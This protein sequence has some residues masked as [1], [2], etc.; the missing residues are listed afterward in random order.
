MILLQSTYGGTV[1]Y[2]GTYLTALTMLDT[3]LPDIVEVN[4]K[5]CVFRNDERYTKNTR[6][7]QATTQ[8]HS[9][10]H[11]N[12][13]NSTIETHFRLLYILHMPL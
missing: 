11:L 1:P 5:P 9:K 3:A 8:Q 12:H 10:D 13:P 2:L 4:L 7:T 6:F